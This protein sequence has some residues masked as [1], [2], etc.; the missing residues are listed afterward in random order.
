MFKM[1]TRIATLITCYNRVEKTMKCLEYLNLQRFT[2]NIFNEIYLHDDGSTDGTSDLVRKYYPSTILF[3][4]D[5]NQYW[6]R[7]MHRVFS[8]AMKGNYTF[9]FWLNDD[10][11]LFPDAIEKMIY[12]FSQI[13]NKLGSP[14]HII[15]GS[16]K[17]PVTD[18][19]TY[20][21]VSRSSYWHP[22][23]LTHLQ[24]DNKEAIE[25]LTMNGNFVLIPDSVVELVGNLDPI[26]HHSKGDF[27]YGLRA[28]K[29]G[30]K[31]WICPGYSG[32]CPRDDI[33]P[34]GVKSPKNIRGFLK[35]IKNPKSGMHPRERIAYVKRYCGKLWF[36]Y[37]P[38]TYLGFALRYFIKK[39]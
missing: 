23:R 21:G 16:T 29:K 32:T 30:V 18:K 2:S 31:I 3:K 35:E 6:C 13:K 39:N 7:G 33:I 9:Y 22:L 15:T 24:P 1:K 5:G 20:G 4:G 26:F 38:I 12:T 27:D 10:T 14:H 11:Y 25:C 36:L 34:V 28:R 37:W 17:D 8:E 19:L